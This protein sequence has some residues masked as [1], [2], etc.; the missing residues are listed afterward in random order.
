L[1]LINGDL[2]THVMAFSPGFLVADRRDG[3]P[4]IFISHGTPDAILPFAMKAFP[5]ANIPRP[6]GRRFGDGEISLALSKRMKGFFDDRDEKGIASVIWMDPINGEFAPHVAVGVR[7]R[8]VEVDQC[9]VV[10]LAHGIEKRV[11]LADAFDGSQTGQG[12][13]AVA[14]GR[15]GCH[16]DRGP[17]QRCQ[18]SHRQQ[19][20]PNLR[21]RKA[22]AHVIA[23]TFED[24]GQ[25]M[26]IQGIVTFSQ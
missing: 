22:K 5:N 14:G 9:P 15:H 16:E 20:V 24:D 4:A 7:K 6:A 11:Q 1:G 8:G 10:L 13:E 18:L 17:V 23:T 25:G 3:R 26:K 21:R 19:V 2:F 12:A